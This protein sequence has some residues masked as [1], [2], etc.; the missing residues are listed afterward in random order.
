MLFKTRGIVLNYLKYSETSIITRIYTDEFG[1]QSYI[2]NGVRSKNSRT[3]IALFQPLTLLDMVV[4]H[5]QTSGLQ[6]IS[7]V[8]CLYPFQTIPFH[9]TRSAIAIFMAEILNKTLKEEA[10]NKELFDYLLYTIQR[11]DHQEKDIENI[12]VKFLIDLSGYLGFMP[13]TPDDI[14]NS[15]FVKPCTDEE[16]DFLDKMIKAREPDQVKTGNSVRRKALEYLI[17]FYAAHIGNFG[18]VNSIKVLKEVLSK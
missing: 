8:K 17:D 12:H 11:L 18:N 2:V 10:S 14:L 6:R 1:L 5:K 13:S 16:K 9:L 15:G 4:Y 7:E 3:R